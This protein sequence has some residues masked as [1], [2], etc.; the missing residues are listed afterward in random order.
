MT[1]NEK[2][3]F[4]I[5]QLEVTDMDRFMSEYAGPLQ[6]INQRHGAELVVASP[7]TEVLEG[8]YKTHMT[9]VIRF[10]SEVKARA[11]YADEEYKPL[12]DVRKNLTNTET[13]SLVLISG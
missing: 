8:N 11:W 7:K 12:I 9:A 2:P 6:P 3:A 1:N 13:S 5:A 10:S 4:L